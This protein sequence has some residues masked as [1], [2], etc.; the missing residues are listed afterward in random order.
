MC[1]LFLYGWPCVNHTPQGAKPIYLHIICPLLKPF[2]ST[3]NASLELPLMIGDFIFTLFTFPIKRLRL[4]LYHMF[5]I[6]ESIL[7]VVIFWKKHT[8]LLPMLLFRNY[9]FWFMFRGFWVW[10]WVSSAS[11]HVYIAILRGSVGGEGRMSHHRI[12]GLLC[13]EKGKRFS[14][15]TTN[16]PMKW[17]LK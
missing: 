15:R 8:H 3:L 17:N 5:W 2:T 12:H 1:K 13:L 6:R 16:A 10:V 14:I 4:A 9:L 11:G 7:Y